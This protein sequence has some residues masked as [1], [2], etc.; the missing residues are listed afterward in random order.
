[1]HVTI[2]FSWAAGTWVNTAGLF[3]WEMLAERG[4]SLW[5]D[6]EY[7][8]II[9]GDNNSIFLSI[10]DNKETILSKKIDLFIA[11]DDY[12]IS[13]NQEIYDLQQII[14]IKGQPKKYP[15]TFA[16]WVSIRLANIPLEDA[17]DIVK[18]YIKTEY[19][20]D[21]MIDLAAWFEYGDQHCWELC[22]MLQFSQKID[23]A[24]QLMFGNQILAEGSIA[25]G[26]EFYSAYPMTPVTSLLE[27]ILEHPEVTFF[28]GEDEIAVAMAMLGARFAGKRAMCATSGWGFALMSESVSFSHQAEIGGVYVLGQRDG[29]S[30]GTPTFTAQGDLSFAMNAGFGETSPIVMAPS[31]FE[32][33]HSMISLALNWSDVYQH[34]LIFLIDKQL[35]EGYKTINSEN[36]TTL[37]INRGEKVDSSI[38][39]TY[40][41][42][43][44][45]SEGISPYAI[46]GQENTLF[47]STSY[48]HDESWA[49]N[50][51]PKIKDEQMQK[52]FRK[53]LTFYKR[54]FEKDFVAYEVI[55]PQAENFFVTR[56]I[57]RYNI[58]ALINKHPNWW[59]IVI[60]IFHPF[61]LH[62]S[63]FFKTH[64]NQIKKLIFVEMNY[65]GQ[66]ERVVRNE[67]DLKTPEW[68]AKISHY[69][70]YTLYPIFIEDLETYLN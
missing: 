2:G 39:D 12:A 68:N 28:Q 7:A 24:Q 13:K 1:M 17:K 26:L 9:K 30:T 21:N 57:N 49:T 31:T 55:N 46:P 15:N 20:A 16:F 14:N 65:E 40:L 19:H 60:K 29:P 63:S 27:V 66:M 18:K 32:E 53:R 67:C 4:Y 51:H 64:E 52:R 56:G 54:E 58:E 69:R 38:E 5:I 10:S 43:K 3:L 70:K 45:T 36:L 47:I 35:A 42:Y 33:L 25:A 34:P 11:F 62:L 37:P 6:K 41:R 50:E 44:V 61:S 22:E 23:T 8:S 59:L 48:E